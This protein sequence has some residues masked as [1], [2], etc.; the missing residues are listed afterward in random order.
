MSSYDVVSH[1]KVFD[2]LIID[3]YH[4]EVVLEHGKASVRE[5]VH[6]GGASAIIPIVAGGNIIFV[7]QYSHPVKY[8][9]LEIPSVLLEDDEYPK[10]CASSDLEE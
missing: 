9:V 1:K 2:G 6:R 7:K 10:N 4:D 3:V 5:I 8:L